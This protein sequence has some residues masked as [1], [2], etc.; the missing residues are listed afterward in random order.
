MNITNMT[1]SLSIVPSSLHNL[2]LGQK[3]RDIETLLFN[4][5]FLAFEVGSPFNVLPLV[6]ALMNNPP[7]WIVESLVEANPIAVGT[8]NEY[9]M[10]PIRVAI[11]SKCTTDVINALIRESPES[12]KC[13]GVSGKTC[14]HLACLY[15]ADLELINKLLEVWPEA[16]EWRDRDG[17]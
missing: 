10:L 8:K 7:L 4:E 13:F 11:R 17:W 9:G 2:L 6:T 12:V 3:W 14:L 15:N 5:P 16:T 1:S